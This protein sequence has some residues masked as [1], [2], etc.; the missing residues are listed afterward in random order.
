MSSAAIRTSMRMA[1]RP[2]QRLASIQRQF[3]SSSPQRKEIRDAYIISASRTP[4]AVAS[5]HLSLVASNANNELVQRKLHDRIRHAT[6]RHSHQVRPRQVKSPDLLDR[7][8]VHGQCTRC[9]RWTSP[10][11]SSCH[12]RRLTH[13][14]RG[15]H[16]QQ[17]MRIRT[18][19]CQHCRFDH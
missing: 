13:Q 15:H 2:Q 16:H 1:S 18:E 10:R 19:G 11:T 7:C 9:R 8:C 5:T 3:S 14:H 17:S 12:F 6:R 4:T